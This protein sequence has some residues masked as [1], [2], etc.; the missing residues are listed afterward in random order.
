VGARLSGSAA[1]SCSIGAILRCPVVVR[2][3]FH[4]WV[5]SLRRC[6]AN[7]SAPRRAGSSRRRSSRGLSTRMSS[8]PGALATV[9]RAQ[10]DQTMRAIE[11]T[12][13]PSLRATD[14]RE[15]PQASNRASSPK[16][17]KPS[18]RTKNNQAQTTRRAKTNKQNEQTNKQ[19]NGRVKRCAPATW[20]NNTASGDNPTPKQ[21]QRPCPAA[22]S[23]GGLRCSTPFMDRLALYLHYFI[24]HKQ[25]NDPGWMHIKVGT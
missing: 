19:A 15:T 22:S 7:R 2:R 14:A 18:K 4:R 6:V 1:R 23:C 16:A 10:R 21:A 5:A 25:S 3:P 20:Q 17:L 8:R 9:V 24:H 12:K 11:P 13:E